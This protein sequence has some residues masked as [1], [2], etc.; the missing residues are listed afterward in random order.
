MAVNTS[1][2]ITIWNRLEPRPRRKDFSRALRAEVR[3]SLWFLTRQW[4]F[5]EFKGEDTGSAI[6][7]RVDMETTRVDLMSLRKKQATAFDPLT[8]M[9]TQ[10][11]K[12]AFNPD[13]S[14]RQEMGR[15]FLRLLKKGLSDAGVPAGTITSTIANLK[16][17][18]TLHFVLPPMDENNGE[19]YGNLELW[20]TY[21]AIQGGRAIDG[22][23]LYEHL[24]A[25]ISNNASDF[26]SS[27]MSTTTT[28]E[29][30]TAGQLFATWFEQNYNYPTEPADSAWNPNRLEY[31]F[32]CSA[33]TSGSSHTVLTADEYYTGK[34][35]WYNFD[36]E[37][38]SA[39]YDASL[40]PAAA[41][42]SHIEREILSVI[43]QSLAFPGMPKPRWWEFED[44][45]VD[46]GKVTAQT[47]DIASLLFLEFALIYS[48]DWMVIPF[49]VAGGSL[50]NIRSAMVKD[51]FGQLTMIEPAGAGS[52]TD[53]QR[54]SMYT[55]TTRED[56][57]SAAD[58]RLF[59]PPVS[60]KMLEAEA[61]ESVN[62]MRDEMANMVWGV[63]VK[64]PDGLGSSMRGVEA[65]A[66]MR[67]YL[68]TV[69]GT[70]TAAGSVEND[71]KVRFELATTVP[72]NWIPFIPV[73][74]G[75]VLSSQIQL[76]RAA[77]PRIM[78][79]ISLT[80]VRPRTDILRE[81]L[82]E[83]PIKG[84]RIFE[85][86]VPRSGAIVQSNWQ[87]A[88]WYDGSHVTWVGRRKTNG[89]GEGNS[90]LRYDNILPKQ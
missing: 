4:Q 71:A 66:K 15:H 32:A 51:C 49:K 23:V 48:N 22:F 79:G 56:T 82:D 44:G 76:Q 26:Y 70:T 30:N 3:D 55:L 53:W 38:N 18:T 35:D 89:R 25:S 62:L 7:V 33:P 50:C 73:R 54:W 61:F 10:A 85:E 72:E 64:V 88:R 90:G 78:D 27:L 87:R 83:Q 31:N 57:P 63:E 65:S 43:P 1:P 36:I 20:Q 13:V 46:F 2:Q 69:A 77:M 9:E 16:A 59:I 29:T 14:L 84:Y 68:K 45:K 17:N 86:E 8:P 47:T 74:L 40:T 34:L 41:N 11:E 5:G 42:S 67:T 80:R 39:D 58:Q 52:S 60:P 37:T 24:K 6:H 21:A 12:F 19:F 75:P 28:S 81:G